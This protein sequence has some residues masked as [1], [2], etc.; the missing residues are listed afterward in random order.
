MALTSPARGATFTAPATINMAANA[1]DPENQLARVEFYNGTTLLGTD[2][3]APYLVLVDERRG[4]HLYTDGGRFRRRRSDRTTSAA[5][6]VTV[7]AL[8]RRP[9]RRA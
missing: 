6:T 2:T 9:D 3:S 5:V 4:G 1:S 8:Q 7:N